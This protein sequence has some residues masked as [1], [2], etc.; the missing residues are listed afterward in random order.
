MA[1]PRYARQA[2]LSRFHDCQV[3]KIRAGC[4]IHSRPL[5]MSGLQCEGVPAVLISPCVDSTRGWRHPSRTLRAVMIET[6]WSA[7]S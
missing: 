5:R 3:T 7:I 6:W 2:E 1:L 4:P